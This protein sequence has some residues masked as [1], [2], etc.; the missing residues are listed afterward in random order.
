M[1]GIIAIVNNNNNSFTKEN[2]DVALE[3]GKSRGPEST[4]SEK[5]NNML[6]GFHRLAING[7]DTGSGQPMKIGNI[8]LICNGEI[9]NY[10]ELFKYIN[11]KPITHSDCEI[12][13][14]LYRLYGIE[15]TLRLLD[16]EFAF[17][18]CD[19]RE[20][21]KPV[22]HYA[23]DPYGVRPLYILERRGHPGQES[24]LSP[25]EVANVITKMRVVNENVFAVAS[26]LK[27][28]HKLLHHNGKQMFYE[29]NK[30][31][32]VKMSIIQMK[33]INPFE[34]K[35]VLPGTF[36]SYYKNNTTGEWHC[37]ENT[38]NQIWHTMPLPASLS[39]SA[40][41][42][43]NGNS[44]AN[45]ST[46]DVYRKGICHMLN[47]AVKKRV[48]GTSDR[49]IACLLSGGLDSSLTT[50]LVKKYYSGELETYSIGMEGSEDLRNARIVAKHLGT[51][52]TE[53]IMKP[54]EFFAAIPNVIRDIESYDTTSV[55]ASVGNYL[56][57]KY[58]AE[59]S[60]AKVILNGDGSDELTG[61]YIYMLKAPDCIEFDRECRRLLSDIYLFDVLRSDKSMSCHGLEPRTPFLDKYFVDYYLRIPAEVRFN[62]VDATSGKRIEKYLLRQ[63][64]QENEPD[65]LPTEILW[66]NKEAFSDGVSGKAGSWFEYIQLHVRDGDRSVSTTTPLT[67]TQGTSRSNECKMDGDR[68]VRSVS[69]TSTTTCAADGS[70][71]TTSTTTPTYSF[72][73]PKTNEQIYYRKIYESNYPDT[74]RIVPYF[75]MPKYVNTDD[76]SALTIKNQVYG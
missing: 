44:N 20:S 7:M 39:A 45:A 57:G 71:S 69:T 27:V 30:N 36:S 35:H 53:I 8:T 38:K 60:K 61:G 3:A 65:L 23:R 25:I 31:Q 76:C 67:P 72:N 55:R 74:E 28:L 18:I 17:A 13:I 59:H 15:H 11:V 1:C 24:T 34:I 5:V 48:V 52:H 56:I 6:F 33:C 4:T 63:A 37:M 66:R 32:S 51:K 26:E 21:E 50:A 16:G 70:V 47:E 68:S 54:E 10:R 62:N 29:N 64:F 22:F 9:F 43:A 19:E 46:I 75:W 40:N 73:P 58:I 12:I 49:P 2:V 41:S 14:H 42:N